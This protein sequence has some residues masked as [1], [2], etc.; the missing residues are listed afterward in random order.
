[1]HKTKDKIS[2]E[3]VQVSRTVIEDPGSNPGVAIIFVIC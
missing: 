3:V 2:K 1:M